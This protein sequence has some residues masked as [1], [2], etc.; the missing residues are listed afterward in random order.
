MTNTHRLAGSGHKG[1]IL[2]AVCLATIAIPMTFTGPAVALSAISHSLGG[3]PRA[4]NWVTNA[5][6]LT[7]GSALMAAGALADTYG[8]KRIFI[9]GVTAFGLLS[10]ALSFAPDI[11]WFDGL[12]AAQGMAAAAACSAGMAALAQE[13]DGPARVRAFSIVGASFGVGLAFGPITSG[14]MTDAFGWRTI[15]YLVF[16]LAASSFVLAVRHLRESTDP[17]AVGLDWPGAM[18]FTLA[19]TLFT[20]AALKAP[21]SGWFDSAVIE[22][23]IGAALSMLAFVIIERRVPRPMLD[24]TLFRYPRFLGAQLLAAAPAYAFVVLLILLPLR[25]TGI[26]GMSAMATGQMMITLSAPLLFLPL[27]AGWLTKWFSMSTLCG[28]GLL[29][30]AGGLLWLSGYPAGNYSLAITLPMVTI[31][32]GISLPWGL[33][34]GLA[35]SVVPKERAGMATGIFN[36]TRVAGE[37]LALAMVFA[38]LSALIAYKLQETAH[39]DA[40]SIRETAQLLVT[41]NLAGAASALPAASQDALTQAYAAAFKLLLMGLAG[42]TVISATIVFLFLGSGEIAEEKVDID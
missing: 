1:L 5:F 25:F 14:L 23:L 34:D 19:L 29:I 18:C 12:R 40:S 4:L 2:L 38:I 9:T 39:P 13:F 35:V 41:G 21:E 24:L 33:M 15:F 3:Q 11:E 16:T 7:F 36:T 10:L 27:A 8:R 32:V 20:C 28:T 26:N 22:L 17:D 30:S 42:V 37:G 31:G 6:M